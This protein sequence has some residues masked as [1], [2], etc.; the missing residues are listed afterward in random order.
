VRVARGLRIVAAEVV[1]KRFVSS[2]LLAGLTVTAVPAMA[3]AEPAATTADEHVVVRV[4][5]PY[6]HDYHPWTRDEQAAYREYLSARHRTYIAYEH[7]KAAERRAYWHW[8][9]EREER[10]EHERR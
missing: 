9:H 2:V 7:Q 6:R 4:Y 5:D 1:M 3:S 8:R 10:L